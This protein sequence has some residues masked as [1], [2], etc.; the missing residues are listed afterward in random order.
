MKILIC[1]V[2]GLSLV[3][4][5]ICSFFVAMV[6]LF[7]FGFEV[8]NGLVSLCWDYIYLKLHLHRDK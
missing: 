3:L 4:L 8:V 5:Y 7:H 6:E 2:D 1:F